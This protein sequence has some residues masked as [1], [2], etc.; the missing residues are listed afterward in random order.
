MAGLSKWRG[1]HKTTEHG[2]WT[3]WIAQLG[4]EGKRYVKRCVDEDQAAREYNKM[5]WKH[6]L[7]ENLNEI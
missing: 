1:V 6:G 2:R 4:H 5:C 7:I 3:Y